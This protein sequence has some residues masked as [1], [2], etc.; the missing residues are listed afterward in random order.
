[1]KKALVWFMTL[2]L[3]CGL[4]QDYTLSARASE[5]GFECESEV[6]KEESLTIGGNVVIADVSD[7]TASGGDKIL[8][9]TDETSDVIV[10]ISDMVYQ[11]G[12]WGTPAKENDP[13]AIALYAIDKRADLKKAILAALQAGKESLDVKEYN[14]TVADD[15]DDIQV[16]I[17]EVINESP[18]LFFVSAGFKYSYNDTQ[19]TKITFVYKD[20]TQEQ[21]DAYMKKL[22]QVAALVTSDMT[23][24]QKALVLH[25]Y[26]AQHIAYAYAE[27]KAGTLSSIP[28]VYN[29]YGALVEG[30]A[31][32]Q[33]YA[34]AYSALLHTVGID[35]DICDSNAM[36]HAWNVVSIGGAWYHV[37]VTWDDPVWNTEGR[38]MHSYFLLSD[39]GIAKGEE[40]H[41]HYDWVDNVEC[42]STKYDDYWWSEITSQIVLV[43]GHYYYIKQN[44]DGLGFQLYESDGN[45]E[46]SKYSSSSRWNVWEGSGYWKTAA[47][48]L[49]KQGNYLYFN[50]NLNLYA[51]KVTGSEPQVVYTYNNNDGYVYGA[52]V[53]ENGTARLNISTTPNKDNDNY[54]TIKLEL[55]EAVPVSNVTLDKTTITLSDGQT[56]KLTATVT[57]EDADNKNVS[58]SSDNTAVATVA[59]DGTVTAVKAGTAKITVTTVDGGKTATCTVTVNCSHKMTKTEA[60]AVTCEEDGNQE[61]WTCSK[62]DKIF[63][64][65]QGNKEFELTDVVIKAT[66]HTAGD[67]WDHDDTNHWKICIKCSKQLNVSG[68]S[69]SDYKFDAGSADCTKDGTETA[70]CE[71]CGMTHTRTAE[72]TMLEHSW[73]EWKTVK[74]ATCTEPGS[75]SSTC[76]VCNTTETREIAA[77]GHTAGDV[78]DHD[79]TNHWKTCTACGQ[80]FDE[81]EHGFIDYKFDAGSADCT[82]DGTETA[83]C[84]V[85]G[86][87]HTRTAAGTML[88]HSW[89]EWKTVKEATCT[90]PGS[91]SSTC[92]VCNTTET[93][94]IAAT[95]HSWGEW[96]TVK[97]PTCSEKGSESSTCAVC[98][99]TETREIAATGH[100]WNVV[101]K[102]AEDYKSVEVVATCGNDTAHTENVENVKITEKIIPATC[103]KAGETTYTATVVLSDGMSFTDS[104]TVPGEAAIGHKWRAVFKW[105]QDY[106]SVEVVATCE[107][108]HAHTEKVANVKIAGKTTP[109][110]CVKAGEITYTATAVL[111]DGTKFTDTKNGPGEAALGHRFSHYVLNSDGSKSVQCDRCGVKDKQNFEIQAS[112]DPEKG[113]KVDISSLDLS[114]IVDNLDRHDVEVILQQE[115]AS[116]AKTAKLKEQI[117]SEYEAVGSFDVQLLLS[118]DGGKTRELTDNFGSILLSLPVG[119][120]YAGR[121]VIVYQLHGNDILTYK[122]LTVDAEGNVTV[123]IDRLSVFTVAVQKAGEDQNTSNTPA[124]Q[125]HDT[126]TSPKT[127][128]EMS[129]VLWISLYA[130]VALA[131]NIVFY[132]RKKRF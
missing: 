49:S 3:L 111:K 65:A 36:N 19:I 68:H 91:K 64:D 73:G 52:M 51:M 39:T 33:G 120:A 29:A 103:V 59:A 106:K 31:V 129:F 61:Y 44:G 74:E 92:T 45:T 58:W 48:Y 85:C 46:T 21:K 86:M 126:I 22:K 7:M 97:E 26:L 131:S 12:G 37:D 43:N 2:C 119:K 112:D 83:K 30:K 100:E 54:T 23:D 109:A 117:S 104:K 107:N 69:A 15:V 79:E 6:H 96:K 114:K 47:A 84:E 132:Y 113:V 118:V 11:A 88:E 98:K 24:E 90:E 66:G 40:G 17:A 130:V 77:T 60:K 80:K 18:E 123:K 38:A 110:T 4:V 105:A 55:P 76:T 16:L 87:T 57:P 78:W 122:D 8:A 121:K 115:E 108:D 14:L 71:V 94:E 82:K 70:K 125:P 81:S 101:F 128:D 99:E 124:A 27:Y 35:A 50:D 127:G 28:N 1:M 32:C 10:D 5:D 42:S 89:G 34:L 41:Q 25:D 53:Y 13:A 62:C 9:V 20:F 95:G 93:R 116:E 56:A 72:G 63:A 102:W 75:K 67:V